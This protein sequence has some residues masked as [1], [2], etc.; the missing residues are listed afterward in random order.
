METAR[1][2]LV[3]DDEPL[4][5]KSCLRALKPKGYE[6]TTTLSG[7]EGLERALSEHFDLVV[8]D[9]KMPDLDGME[10]IRELHRKRPELAMVVITGY[11]TVNS[12]IEATKMGVSE[13][14]EKPFTP[15][16]IAA[17]VERTFEYLAKVE[18]PKPVRI[19]VELVK[20]VLR[21][22]DARPALGSELLHKGSRALSGYALSAM[23][24]AAIVAG[25]LVWIEKEAG[26]LSEGERAWL[27]R[28]LE[29]EIW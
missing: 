6:V 1:N 21:D 9:L 16:E 20:R 10:L 2:I 5:A 7:R 12:A 18:K 8:T 17:A 29:A 25:D 27:F 15:E 22:I 4:V 19:N 23:E 28:R 24:K 11:G 26:P 14:I 13:F 3:V